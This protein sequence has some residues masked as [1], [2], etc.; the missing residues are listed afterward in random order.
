MIHHSNYY[1]RLNALTTTTITQLLLSDHVN[2]DDTLH[3]QVVYY[4]M[5]ITLY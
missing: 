2:Y 3:R 4:S 5:T 1:H